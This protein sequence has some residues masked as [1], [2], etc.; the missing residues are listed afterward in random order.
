MR[1]VPRH[2][3]VPKEYET[4]A[5]DDRPIPIG[6]G[7]TISQPYMVALMTEQL[8]VR[9]GAKVLEVGTGSGYQAAILSV[10]GAKV[11]SIER[12]PELA[13]SAQKRLSELGYG[14]VIVRCGDGSLGW[15]QEAPF[16]GIVLTAYVPKLPDPLIQQLA[17]GGR[18]VAPVGEAMEQWLVVGTYREGRLETKTVC[19]CLFVPLIGSEGVQ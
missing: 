7:Q 1:E 13:V 16:D 14:N 5:Y 11:Y 19:G 17:D 15:P 18:I 12:I 6:A 10:L 8:S 3:F 9:P 4:R 2:R